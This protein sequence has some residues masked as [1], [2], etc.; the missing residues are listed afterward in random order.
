MQIKNIHFDSRRFAKNNCHLFIAFQTAKNDGHKYLGEVYSSG[1]KHEA[2]D[3]EAFFDPS[4]TPNFKN[5]L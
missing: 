4:R 5:C 2:S 3:G 1:I